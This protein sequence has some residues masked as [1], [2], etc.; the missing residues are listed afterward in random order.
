MERSFQ[1]LKKNQESVALNPDGPPRFPGWKD[2]PGLSIKILERVIDVD[3]R[4][5]VIMLPE[6]SEAEGSLNRLALRLQKELPENVF[7][8]LRALQPEISD[9]NGKRYFYQA[10]AEDGGFETGFLKKSYTILVDVIKNG[11]IAKCHFSPRK[12]TILGHRKGGT[13]ALAAAASWDE[14]ELGG[15]I[16]IGG[17]MPAFTTSTIKAKTLALVLSGAQGNINE[18]AL[19]RIKEHFTDVEYDIRRPSNDD[20]PEAEN[21]GVLLDFFA[22]RLRGEEWTKQAII[23]FGMRFN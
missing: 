6:H 21:I 11:L 23:S 1:D 10:E 7:I 19:R 14:I 22:H 2:F 8:L 17:T 18:A 4:N 12:I 16:S 3:V 5:C 20:I 15:V 9:K 13:V